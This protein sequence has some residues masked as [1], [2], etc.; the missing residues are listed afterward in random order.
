MS[1]FDLISTTI[2]APYGVG[3]SA[4]QLAEAITDLDTAKTLISSVLAF[5][6]EVS[7]SLQSAFIDEMNLDIEAVKQVAIE[8]QDLAGYPMALAA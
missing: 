3:V 7:V 5:F 8:F 1:A 6:S 4:S 2:D